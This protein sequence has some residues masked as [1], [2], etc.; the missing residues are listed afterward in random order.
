MVFSILKNI[1]KNG[2]DAQQQLHVLDI[3]SIVNYREQY[4]SWGNP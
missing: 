2:W 3:S 1:I 4:S